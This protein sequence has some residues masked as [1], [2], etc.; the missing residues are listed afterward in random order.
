MENQYEYAWNIGLWGNLWII[1]EQSIK[2]IYQGEIT[3]KLQPAFILVESSTQEHIL[4]VPVN[5]HATQ[6]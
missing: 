2:I 1:W 4:E 3:S 5:G 6:I